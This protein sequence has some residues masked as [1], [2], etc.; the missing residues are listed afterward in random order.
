MG[1]T[2]F[3]VK[4][5]KEIKKIVEIVAFRGNSGNSGRDRVGDVV[6]NS[7]QRGT[8]RGKTAGDL[9]ERVPLVPLGIP[10]QTGEQIFLVQ[11][12]FPQIRALSF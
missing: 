12:N 5:F 8:G 1:I 7:N 3:F 6:L 10:I 2:H 9:G 4:M 11:V